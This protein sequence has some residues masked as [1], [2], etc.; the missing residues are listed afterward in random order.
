M[1]GHFSP[2]LDGAIRPVIFLPHFLG[3]FFELCVAQKK[4]KNKNQDKE[5]LQCFSLLTPESQ[6]AFVV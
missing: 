5:V 4:I 2:P 3:S 6:K 1:T